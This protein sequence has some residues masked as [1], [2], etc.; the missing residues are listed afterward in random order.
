M[1]VIQQERS[2]LRDLLWAMEEG[3]ISVDGIVRIE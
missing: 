1:M 3:V 2:E